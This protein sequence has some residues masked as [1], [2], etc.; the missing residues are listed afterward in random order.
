[1]K[2]LTLT[3]ELQTPASNQL[4]N[5]LFKIVQASSCNYYTGLNNRTA[6]KHWIRRKTNQIL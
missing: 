6:W 1:M 2:C 3:F 4:I 5:W